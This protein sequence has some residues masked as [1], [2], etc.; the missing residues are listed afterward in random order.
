MHLTLFGNRDS[1]V[2]LLS[3]LTLCTLPGS[4]PPLC[5]GVCPYSCPLIQWRYLT[6]S[7][8]AALF[9]FCPQYFPA[10]GSFPMSHLFSLD[11]QSIGASASGSVLP[12]NIQGWFPLGLTGWSP[13]HPRD[14]Q[15]TSPAPQF[16]SINSSVLS[17]LYG[18]TLIS[19]HDYQ[20]NSSFDYM[21]LCRQGD[22][23]AFYYPV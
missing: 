20:K 13:C 6:L 9:S 4:Y 16:E 18:P 12:V 10:S 19:I 7:S 3:C 21:D 11:G 17:L 2:Q 8:S 5:P 1:V 22:V 14:S 15:E 23:S